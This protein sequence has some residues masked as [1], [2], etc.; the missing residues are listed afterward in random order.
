[1]DLPG[2]FRSRC[3]TIDPENCREISLA[4]AQTVA[5]H[6]QHS[7]GKIARWIVPAIFGDWIARGVAEAHVVW[8]QT[9]LLLARATGSES[10]L[11]ARFKGYI[12]ALITAQRRA[13]I[14]SSA[15]PDDRARM[16]LR[17]V[18]EASPDVFAPGHTG[19]LS[20]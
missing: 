10:A 8:A 18:V 20:D 13:V 7:I 9:G 1:M 17:D 4:S 6:F 19:F 3:G 5:R 15:A 16:L 11:N 2:K 12:A 14:A